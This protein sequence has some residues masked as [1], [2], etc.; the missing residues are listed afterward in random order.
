MLFR[1]KQTDSHQT[2]HV[3]NGTNILRA[4]AWRSLNLSHPNLPAKYRGDHR[5]SR[6]PR[7]SSG[8]KHHQPARAS[9]GVSLGFARAICLVRMPQE[10]YIQCRFSRIFTLS[11]SLSPYSPHQTA[12]T[13]LCHLPHTSLNTSQHTHGASTGASAEQ[14]TGQ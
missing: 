2:H 3:L 8:Y 13:S 5:D 7:V 11:A 4:I 9:Q 14:D 1:N 6:A 12:T 10:K